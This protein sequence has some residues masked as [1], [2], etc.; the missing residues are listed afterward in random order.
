MEGQFLDV[1]FHQGRQVQHDLEVDLD[2]FLDA[3]PLDLERDL[4]TVLQL[5]P[6][7]LPDG[8]RCQRCVVELGKQIFEHY[9]QLGLDDLTGGVGGK[10]RHLVLK[11]G[12]FLQK[13]DRDQV[14]TG[15]QNLSELDVCRT[16]LL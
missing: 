8:G 2:D 1:V 10:R 13:V 5:G 16:E 6:V 15:R 14:R 7:H 11:L 4:P 12:E 3:G 9:P